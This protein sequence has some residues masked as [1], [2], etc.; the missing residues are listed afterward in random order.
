MPRAWPI[1]KALAG[2][3]P[4]LIPDFPV[5]PM[6]GLAAL[7]NFLNLQKLQQQFMDLILA[8]LAMLGYRAIIL[9]TFGG[10]G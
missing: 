4:D 9:A 3:A 2:A 1:A 7:R 8:I 5:T 10:P 6:L